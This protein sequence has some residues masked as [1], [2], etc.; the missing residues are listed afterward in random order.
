MDFIKLVLSCQQSCWWASGFKTWIKVVIL[1]VYLLHV[2]RSWFDFGSGCCPAVVP[3]L[4][5]SFS[6]TRSGLDVIK[7]LD[8]TAGLASKC[9]FWRHALKSLHDSHKMTLKDPETLNWTRNLWMSRPAAEEIVLHKH[10]W[11]EW[12]WIFPLRHE[13]FLMSFMSGYSDWKSSSRLCSRSLSLKTL[14]YSKWI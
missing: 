8:A 2:R 1:S 6:F 7:H 5:A 12:S 10:V 13:K 14:R 9:G 3:L 4:V 11:P